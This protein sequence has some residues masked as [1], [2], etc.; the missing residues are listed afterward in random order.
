[1]IGSF[2]QVPI[3]T[4]IAY[5]SDVLPGKGW[6]RCDGTRI[7]EKYTELI[8]ILGGMTL[9]PNLVGRTLIGSGKPYN[10]KQSDNRYPNFDANTSWKAR[11]TGGEYQHQLTI[12]EMPVHNHPINNGDFGLHYQSFSGSSETKGGYPFKTVYPP[13][14]KDDKII[15]STNTSGGNGAHNTMQPYFAVNYIIFAGY[16]SSE[17]N[18][19]HL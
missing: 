1:M 2:T 11:D 19:T 16:D 18:P 5:P 9:T 6:L 4:I 17:K 3:G 8:N 12:N 15:S 10:E 14:K 13:Y 7:E